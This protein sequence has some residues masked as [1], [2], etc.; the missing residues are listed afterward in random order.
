L[1]LADYFNIIP[2]RGRERGFIDKN[3][4]GMTF[5]GSRQHITHMFIDKAEKKTICCASRVT[6]YEMMSSFQKT[7]YNNNYQY[8]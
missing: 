6:W 8:D 7:R 5:A 4:S 3:S 1:T 2:S